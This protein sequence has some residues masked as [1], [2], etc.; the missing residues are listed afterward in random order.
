MPI[1]KLHTEDAA[2]LGD[3]SVNPFEEVG[4]GVV[5]SAASTEPQT[6]EGIAIVSRKLI[7]TDADVVRT[8]MNLASAVHR[9][10]SA[11]AKDVQET[12]L[13]WAKEQ[14]LETF[15]VGSLGLDLL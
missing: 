7:C 6:I 8:L 15:P 3:L 4:V 13:Q 1:S 5:F 9:R 14:P 10:V 11:H 12:L 2:M